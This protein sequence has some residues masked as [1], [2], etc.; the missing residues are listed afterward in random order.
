MTVHQLAP[1]TDLKPKPSVTGRPANSAT[2]KLPDERY[3][4][5]EE[6]SEHNA[7]DDI[8]VTW[9]GDVYDLTPLFKAHLGD[10]L[11][12]PILRNAGKDISY[13]FDP[14]TRDLRT[15]VHPLTGVRCYYTPEGRFLH[16]PIPIPRTDSKPVELPWWLDPSYRIGKLSAKTRKIRIVNT[17]TSDEHT[18]QVCS[19]ERLSAI[20]DRYQALNSHAKGYMW[21][22]LGTLL[23]MSMT[24]EQNGIRDDSEDF[25][26]VGVMD[27]DEWLPAIHLYFS[28]DLTVA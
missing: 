19:E 23:D 18:I 3:F 21:K 13:W 28:D 22:R 9:L 8:W 27:E 16:V 10:P 25:H 1:A 2:P 4:T 26:R 7:P 14:A 20:Q 15:H 11:M 12:T 6:V 5:P 24:L 17:L